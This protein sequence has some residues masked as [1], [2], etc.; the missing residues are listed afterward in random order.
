MMQCYHKNL[1][2]MG[3]KVFGVAPGFLATDFAGPADD[4]RRMGAIEPEHGAEIIVKVVLGDR[5]ADVGRVVDADGV[6]DW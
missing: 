5:D 4:M 6:Q 3:V 2:G 1:R